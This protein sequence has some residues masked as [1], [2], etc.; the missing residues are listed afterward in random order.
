ALLEGK[1]MREIDE[2]AR[3]RAVTAMLRPTVRGSGAHQATQD[4]LPGRTTHG[5]ER[6]PRPNQA[7]PAEPGAPDRTSCRAQVRPEH[8]RHWPRAAGTSAPTQYRLASGIR[9]RARSVN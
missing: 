7:L 6:H 8:Y 1:R 9:S 3:H 5:P 2:R 4:F